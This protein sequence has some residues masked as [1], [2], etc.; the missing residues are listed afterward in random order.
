MNATRDG[1]LYRRA[2]RWWLA[3]LSGLYTVCAILSWTR[4][5]HFLV[6]FGRELY[7]PWRLAS[8]DVLYRDVAYFNG[9]L[10]PMLNSWL[11]RIFGVQIH[12]LFIANLLIGLG[13][14]WLLVSIMRRFVGSHVAGVGGL[15]FILMFAFNHWLNA[16]I[17]SYVAPYSHEMTHGLACSLLSLFCLGNP[18][19]NSAP[20]ESMRRAAVSG[21]LGGIVFLTKPEIFLALCLGWCGWWTVRIVSTRNRVRLLHADHQLTENSADDKWVHRCLRGSASEIISTLC[22]GLF[23]VLLVAILI[24]AEHRQMSSWTYVLGG[25]HWVGDHSVA[26]HPFYKMILGTDHLVDR[27]GDQ[28]RQLFSVAAIIF[29]VLNLDRAWSRADSRVVSLM[30]GLLSLAVAIWLT[31]KG[32]LP[33]MLF[34]QGLSFA[35]LSIALVC[36]WHIWFNDKENQNNKF[37]ANGLPWTLFALGMLSKSFFNPLFFHYGFVLVLPAAMVLL[38]AASAFVQS[39]GHRNWQE[40]RVALNLLLMVV[41]FDAGRAASANFQAVR[42]NDFAIGSGGDAILVPSPVAVPAT[43][44]VKEA[45]ETAHELIAAEQTLVVLPEG[46]T[47]NYFSRRKS[48]V[49]YTNYMPIEFAMFGE[50]QIL[51][52]L[53]ASPPDFVMLVDRDTTEYGSVFG[54]ADYGAEVLAWVGANYTEVRTFGTPVARGGVFGIRMLQRRASRLPN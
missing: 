29:A 44:V 49:V 8:G 46:I 27:I 18:T 1:D 39:I 3:G 38:V 25:W 10:S 7:V 26:N 48:S 15:V 22:A 6:D 23:V 28:W 31:W 53:K 52:S 35:T 30:I 45:I 11:F 54:A 37:F 43:A 14:L 13:I 41:L 5:N 32:P 33:R 16:G 51:K 42:S 36:G 34:F 47:I 24:V 40:G 20:K 50:E 4:L 2:D 19:S 9:P 17:F 12:V 21:L